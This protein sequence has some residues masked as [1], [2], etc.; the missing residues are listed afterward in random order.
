MANLELGVA[1]SPQTVMDIGSTGKQFTAFSIQLLAG[2]G[3][4]GLDDDVRKWI[5]EIPD[6]GKT[7]TIRN[8]L[9]HTGGLRDYI[10]LFDL[11]GVVAEDLSTREDTLHVLA[12]QKAPNF[13]PGAEHLYSNTGYFLL[14]EIVRRASG[15]SLR[16]FAQERIFTPLGMRHTQYNDLHTR[17]IPGRATGYSKAET[18]GFG[19][20]MSDWEQVGDG[21]VLTSVEDLQRWDENFY[22][23][24]VGGRAVID[25]MLVPGVLSSGKKLQYA[26]ALFVSE[27]RGLQSVAHG[28]AWAGYRAQ[29]LRFPKEHL[30]VACICN[31][32]ESNPSRLAQKVAEVY[33]GEKMT[34]EPG[35]AES[36]SAKPARPAIDPA[37][38]KALEGAY[39]D[40]A[41]DRFFR[42]AVENGELAGKWGSRR[43]VLAP[44]AANRYRV[45]GL[46]DGVRAEA[47]V[48]AQPAPGGRPR[49][50]VKIDDDGDVE[51]LSFEPVQ[52]WTPAPADLAA[53]A[54]RYASSELDT[55]VAARGEGR[56]ALPALPRR[57]RGRARPER[58]RPD[59][60][61]RRRPPL[62]PR[63]LGPARR[64][65]GRRGPRAGY[66]V[67][68]DAG[69]LAGLPGFSRV[70][71]L[72]AARRL[73]RFSLYPLPEGGQSSPRCP[74]G[75]ASRGKRGGSSSST[76]S[77]ARS[78]PGSRTTSRR[79]ES[80]SG[81]SGC[82]SPARR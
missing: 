26:S 59:E 31:L 17:L 74:N 41:S 22:T 66:R 64:F 68:Q 71:G 24:A 13:A 27:Y 18:G 20:D 44:V 39:L 25:A 29:L 60:R 51:D 77:G 33:L 43:I 82:P 75:G 72:P 54:G 10:V 76:T 2:E 57:S 70:P 47:T 40:R 38:A 19:I 12:R 61:R 5:P 32:G 56:E 36:A 69:E 49:L 6:Y 30:S 79:R 45:E 1:N 23:G 28:G 62:H 34:K 58:R 14:G 8:L 53:L 46:G 50:A 37:R 42:L 21:G 52:L 65:H 11:Q 7:V 78:A 80:S 55:D 35:P 73:A 67:S 48:G 9:H 15:K 81:A 63:R 16:D 4:L 3:K